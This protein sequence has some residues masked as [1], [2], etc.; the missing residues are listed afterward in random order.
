V[1]R[2]QSSQPKSPVGLET[3]I[4]A[5]RSRLIAGAQ[6]I[7]RS[8]RRST[9]AAEGIATLAKVAESEL[10]ATRGT[11]K[12]VVP[13]MLTEKVE[14]ANVQNEMDGARRKAEHEF[15]RAIEDGA[16]ETYGQANGGVRDPRRTN[17]ADGGVRD[18]RRT[19]TNWAGSPSRSDPPRRPGPI[20]FSGACGGVII[21]KI[22][23]S[24]RL[25]PEI[26]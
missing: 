13:L 11:W 26:S 14:R 23:F 21:G 6:A 18:P 16:E 1:S 15:G 22:D 19:G 24:L 2:A 20:L 5:A 9:R 8:A 12:K 3:P 25:V 17:E 7:G 4:T 10:R